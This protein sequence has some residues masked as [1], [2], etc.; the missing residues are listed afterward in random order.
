MS[1]TLP[2]WFKQR[3]CKAE[4][5]GSDQVL[6]ISGPNLAESFLSVATSKDGHWEAALRQTADGPPVAI[7][8]GLATT[9]AAWD[10]AFELYRER[11][12]C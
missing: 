11:I 7:A 1:P 9:S 2:F 6:K 3:Q 10:A 8:E 12:I 5:A 4:P